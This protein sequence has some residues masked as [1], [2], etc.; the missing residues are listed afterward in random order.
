MKVKKELD[1]EDTWMT[2][3]TKTSDEAG[4]STSSD[5][6]I[7]E[8]LVVVAPVVEEVSSESVNTDVSVSTDA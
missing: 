6:T 5:A 8:P 2:N 1:E 3:K 7:E 4:P